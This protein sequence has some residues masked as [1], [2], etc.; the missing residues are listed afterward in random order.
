MAAKSTLKF[1]ITSSDA[2][3][4]TCGRYRY[5]LRRGWDNPAALP[6]EVCFIMLNPS[7]ADASRDDPTIRRCIRF[8]QEWGYSCLSVRNLFSLRA[9]NPA[10]LL[11]APDPIG[12][13]GVTALKDCDYADL[14]VAAWG[15]KPPLDRDKAVLT[16]LGGIPLFCLGK[17]KEGYPRHP[18]YVRADQPLLP[19]P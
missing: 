8:A 6:S 12:P 9:T 3:I 18:L 4:S 10:E 17:T 14:V 7:T 19:Y 1:P 11:R 2:N 13:R 5:W 15:A 16:L